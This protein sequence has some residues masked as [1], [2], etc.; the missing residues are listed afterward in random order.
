MVEAEH[1]ATAG[2]VVI[3]GEY[4]V[5]PGTS[6]EEMGI[7]VG[8]EREGF[9]LA[10]GLTKTVESVEEEKVNWDALSEQAADQIIA[11][12]VPYLPPRVYEQIVDGQQQIVGGHPRVVSL[13]VNF[14]G[15]DYDTDLDAGPKLQ[16]YFS[17][18][19]G[20]IHR[21]GGRLNRVITGA[22]GSLL[23][24]L[25]GA[26]V[27]HEDNE[28]RAV[29]CALEMQQVA[30]ESNEMP[31]I[32]DQRIGVAS[33]PVFAGNVGSE[34]RREYTV[35]GDIVNLS[36]RLMQAAEM[37]DIL[38]DQRTARRAE[39]KL[40]CEELTPIRVKGKKEPGLSAGR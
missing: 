13:F 21:Y 7:I 1:H 38:T 5:D 23:H 26:P 9:L 10:E 27:A 31:F 11:Q 8:Q 25:F 40:I 18:M 4:T 2:E 19:Q 28:E 37:G 6:W 33:G 30:M 34:R 39:G 24:L 22:K 20:I 32:T 29:G 17:V 35:M 12:L 3:D 36:A 14:F 16:Q 15:L